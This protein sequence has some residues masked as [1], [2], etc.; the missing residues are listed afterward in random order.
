M[1]QKTKNDLLDIA[2]ELIVSPITAYVKGRE[3]YLKLAKSE[4]ADDVKEKAR[5]AGED[6]QAAATKA[7]EKACD[8]EAGQKI[9]EAVGNFKFGNKIAEEI[10]AED[11]TENI[12]DVINDVDMG[13]AFD[14]P[15]DEFADPAKDLAAEIDEASEEMEQKV[16]EALSGILGDI[17][18]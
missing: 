17:T 2:A 5:K 12:E 15:N 7:F 16:D 13:D 8:S 6:I 9:K 11:I 10:A 4:A 14:E 3:L 1:K 18:Q